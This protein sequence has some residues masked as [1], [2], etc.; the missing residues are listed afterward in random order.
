MT[1]LN[2]QYQDS[3]NLN[4]RIKIHERFSTNKEDWHMW[5]FD[6]YDV[7][8]ESKILELG[9]GDGTFWKK[10]G[11]RFPKGCAITL[12]DFSSGMLADA[13]RRIGNLP[14]VTYQIVDI[15]QI[16]FDD[17][18]FDVVIA[19]HM[20][21][22]VPDRERALKEVRRVLKP[23]G[24][25]YSSTIGKEHMGGFNDL[26]TR[27]DP[28][29]GFDLTN[30]Q[31]DAFGLENGAEQLNHYFKHVKLTRFPGDLLIDDVQAICDYICSSGTNAN[32]ALSGKKRE[33]F[34]GFLNHEKEKNGGF[35]KITKATGLFESK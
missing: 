31:A 18:Y 3:S 26:L 12:S 7:K 4:I 29:F 6:H 22:H 8:P 27:F 20:L 35:I 21:Y 32:K 13:Q 11:E 16:P 25:F 28:T 1:E 33:Q 30:V 17:H 19:N 34:L 9:C 23:G 5:L 2:E 10:N 24:I 15:Q 14:N